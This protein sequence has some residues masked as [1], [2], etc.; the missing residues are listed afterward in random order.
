M[1]ERG[2]HG[3]TARARRVVDSAPAPH[4]NPLPASGER[5]RLPPLH[6]RRD[7]SFRALSS[8][9]SSRRGEGSASGALAR[10]ASSLVLKFVDVLIP[11]RAEPDEERE[12][13]D[14]ALHGEALHQ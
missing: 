2:L 1:P 7:I 13:L 3:E 5:E 6:N 9:A 11:L 4:P 14:I 10:S 8:A 12:G